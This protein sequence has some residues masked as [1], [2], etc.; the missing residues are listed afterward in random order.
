MQ[1]SELLLVAIYVGLYLYDSALLMYANEAILIPIGKDSWSVAFGSNKT[2]LKG[3]EVYLPNP[4]LPTQL[5]FRL[6]WKFEKNASHSIDD[7]TIR[8]DSLKEFGPA[9]WSLFALIFGFLPYAL[10]SRQGDLFIL[11]AFASIYINVVLITLLL[12][13]KRKK[14]ELTIK[15][16]IGIAIDLIIC[17]PFALNIIRRLSLRIPV[18]EDLVSAAQRLQTSESWEKTKVELLTRLDDEIGGEDDGTSRKVALLVR[19][20]TISSEGHHVPS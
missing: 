19:R 7:W 8:R 3:K 6:S 1:H 10:F 2:T 15:D 12:W 14:N 11:L 20:G 13:I 4:I 16:F 18:T 5:L 17:P 9:V